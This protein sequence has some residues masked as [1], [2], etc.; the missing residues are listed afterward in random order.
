MRRDLCFT[1]DRGVT[2]VYRAYLTA[3]RD[4]FSK[5]AEPQ[6][7]H[8]LTFGLNMSFKYNMNGGSCTVHLMPYGA[9]TAVDVRY[10]IVQAAG[11]RYEA[12]GNALNRRVESILGCAAVPASLDVELFLLPE[13]QVLSADDP[14]VARSATGSPATESPASDMSA[15][16]SPA[17][18][19]PA[20]P[21]AGETC[22]RC[23]APMKSGA[24]FC[25]QCGAPCSAPA[26]VRAHKFCTACGTKLR[27][28][29][30]FCSQCGKQQNA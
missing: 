13:N 25:T 12:H 2:D 10:T 9:G 19:M 23:G 28:D 1:F 14:R 26:A 27:G 15:T 22:A 11:A 24:R 7:Y 30:R 17:T 21:A 20:V 4:V 8:T 16:G 3:I 18:D 29:A 6:P 5:D